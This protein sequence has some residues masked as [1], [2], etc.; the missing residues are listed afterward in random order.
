MSFSGKP[1]SQKD[2]FISVLQIVVWSLVP[3]VSIKSFKLLNY[4]ET[5][6]ELKKYFVIEYLYCLLWLL[7]PLNALRFFF[8]KDIENK[9]KQSSLVIKLLYEAIIYGGIFLPFI[10]W[11]FYHL[12]K[13]Y[14][15]RNS[16]TKNL[17]K[18]FF[19]LILS[20][21]VD[22]L[23]KIIFLVAVVIYKYPDK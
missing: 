4:F 15:V 10:F 8:S 23:L 22:S 1:F 12:H 5:S 6:H 9:F 21:S 17:A 16:V 19:W 11:F 14:N 20:F 2:I 13:K 18:T 7:F 3:Y